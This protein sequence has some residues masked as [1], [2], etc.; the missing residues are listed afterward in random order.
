MNASSREEDETAATANQPVNGVKS[1]R[2]GSAGGVV[3]LLRRGTLI[4]SATFS[5]RDP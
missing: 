2:G 1:A 5:H 4:F 3:L